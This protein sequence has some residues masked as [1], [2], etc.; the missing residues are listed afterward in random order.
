M[1]DLRPLLIRPGPPLAG[2]FAP[3]GD[4]SI[5]HRAILLGL[6]A[7][8]ET[9][10]ER[11]NPGADCRSS[12]A[13]ARAL[14]AGA[15]ETADRLV[16]TGAAGALREPEGVLDCGNSGT[17][18]RLLAGVLAGQ[19]L[20]AVLAGDASLHRRPVARIV[21]PLRR[22]GATLAARDGDRLPPLVVRGGPLTPIHWDLPV[23]S[24]QVATCVLLAA[25]AARGTTT[26]SLPGEARDHTER[27]LPAFGVPV[28]IEPR[29]GAGPRLA[30][31]GPARPR[32]AR[33]A[34]PGDPSAAAFFLAAAASR[35]GARVTARAVSLNPTRSAFLDV[36]EAMGAVVERLPTSAGAGEPVGD[37][38]VTGPERLEAFDVPAAWVPRLLDEVPAWAVVASAARGVSRIAGARELRVKESDRLA[39]LAR[40]LSRL[41]V[42]CEEAP[43]GLAIE[44]G[45]VQGGAVESAGDH[46]IAMAF[47]ILGTRA[48]G[49]VR[50]DDAAS[51]PTSYPDFRA[52]LAALGGR[53]SEPS[54]PRP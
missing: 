39:A 19:P 13:C 38:T 50:V 22:M 23:A 40:N 31:D 14:G 18:L 30:I 37:V 51:V 41:G 16:L 5:T 20:L 10:I 8:G 36:L 11:P 44:G 46:R 7:E 21:E 9:T 54:D 27:M 28:G 15:R 2:E 34:V 53:V 3:P 47:A 29:A 35:P 33:L 17:T 42:R 52:T 49:D 32:G 26:V 4:K 25:L 24:A 45:P 1:S 6:L 43:D 48:R 12:L